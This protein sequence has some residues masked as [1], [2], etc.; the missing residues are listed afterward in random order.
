MEQ[1]S[2]LAALPRLSAVPASKWQVC[3][4]RSASCDFPPSMPYSNPIGRA[5][6]AA[7]RVYRLFDLSRIDAGQDGAA[8]ILAA[9]RA[10]VGQVSPLHVIAE[11]A[12]FA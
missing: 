9:I 10:A 11:H 6:E 7:I 8:A 3:G 5:A 2:I 1:A 4:A 12:G